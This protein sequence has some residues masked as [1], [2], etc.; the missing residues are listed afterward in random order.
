MKAPR[1]RLPGH[2]FCVLAE[3]DAVRIMLHIIY[4]IYIPSRS[5]LC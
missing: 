1:L 4:E 2:S 5:E 3:E